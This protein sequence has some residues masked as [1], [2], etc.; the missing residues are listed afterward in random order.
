MSL[1]RPPMHER[2]FPDARTIRKT[3]V[4]YTRALDIAIDLRAAAILEV[5]PALWLAARKV[6][7][8]AIMR[9]MRV[10]MLIWNGDTWKTRCPLLYRSRR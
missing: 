1:P 8:A 3:A 2:P 5:G 7:A 9:Y 4:S 6:V 10:P